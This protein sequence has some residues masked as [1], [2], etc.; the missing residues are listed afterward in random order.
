MNI[1]LFDDPIIR[2]SLLPLTF[3]RPVAEIRVGILKISEKWEKY[4]ETISFKTEDYL[5]DKYPTTS[6]Q[7]PLYIN[8]AI[9]PSQVL[10]N[11][12]QTLDKSIKHRVIVL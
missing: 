11:A 12:I 8:G 7:D 4:G 9:C 1:V 10:I 5:S 2:T 3:T 6:D